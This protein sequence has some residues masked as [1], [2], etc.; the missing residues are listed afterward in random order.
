MITL[1]DGYKSEMAYNIEHLQTILKQKKC[2]CIFYDKDEKRWL[3][4]Y[5]E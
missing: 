2:E 1:K 3:V 4:I 5:A